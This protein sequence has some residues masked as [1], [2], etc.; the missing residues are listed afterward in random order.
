MD[1]VFAWI[2]NSAL[3]DWVRDSDCTCAF[4]IIVT[5]HNI[6]MAFLAGGSIVVDLSIIGLAPGIS[7]KP[8]RG[9]VPLLWLAFALIAVT[10]ILLLIAYPTK[11]LTN[12][13]FY[14]KLCLVAVAIWLVYRVATDVLRAP[15]VDA[16]HLPARARVLAIASLTTW[17]ALIAAG[18]F[19]AYTHKWEMLGIPAVL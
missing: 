9:F 14:V 7:L 2:E 18:R 19:L 1:P 13:L 16:K 10:G 11:A 8:M 6:G 4:P 12:P 5:L 3:S 17:A 15:E